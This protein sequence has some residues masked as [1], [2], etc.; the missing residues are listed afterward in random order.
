MT[1]KCKGQIP[2]NYNTKLTPKNVQ[3]AA[4]CSHF[5]RYSCK[6]GTKGATSPL[7]LQSMEVEAQHHYE[8]T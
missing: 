5:D 3:N 7:S 2:L 6:N 1:F 4:F 8:E